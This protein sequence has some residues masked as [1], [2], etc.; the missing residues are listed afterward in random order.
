ME[1]TLE[2]ALAFL[3]GYEDDLA[4]LAEPEDV[5]MSSPSTLT[6]T[7]SSDDAEAPDEAS[8]SALTKSSYGDATRFKRARQ[9]KKQ[10][11]DEL[12]REVKALEKRLKGMKIQK[13]PMALVLKS[14]LDKNAVWEA[15]ALRNKQERLE[16]EFVNR[17]LKRMLDAALRQTRRLEMRL[18]QPVNLNSVVSQKNFRVFKSSN[19]LADAVA[20]QNLLVTADQIQAEMDDLYGRFSISPLETS[21][22]A[23]KSKR[24]I[25]CGALL[26]AIDCRTVS[27]DLKLA[28]D[29]MWRYLI[30]EDRPIESQLMADG[31]TVARMYFS[32]LTRGDYTASYTARDVY[33][34]V[35]SEDQVLI[36][37]AS[38]WRH[39]LVASEADL[40]HGI[41]RREGFLRFRRM[42]DG[43]SSIHTLFRL[44][45]D[46]CGDPKCTMTEGI[47]SMET[48]MLDSAVCVQL[49]ISRWIEAMETLILNENTRKLGEIKA[50][51]PFAAECSGLKV[52]VRPRQQATS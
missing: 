46:S 48:Q 26:E 42:P 34:R 40:T 44:Q 9:R 52:T 24:F 41:L 35:V 5:L 12:R 50:M 4:L 15:T 36:I 43:E 19:P 30:Y 18:R 10:E 37:W 29:S 8:T 11:M 28:S 13:S 33:R 1:L 38:S 23:V 6:S 49:E 2:T 45:L 14:T 3:D 20:L 21:Y 16:A 27:Y 17:Q 47:E 32:D 22:A 25:G 31:E 39:D 51:R 7:T